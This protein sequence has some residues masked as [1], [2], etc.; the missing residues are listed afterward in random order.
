[1]S[2]VMFGTSANPPGLHHEVTVRFLASKF[3]RVDVWPCGPRT[4]GKNSTNGTAPIHRAAMADLAYGNI[5]GV[6]VESSDLEQDEF[7]RTWKIR[8][9]YLASGEDVW[10]AVGTDLV[11]GGRDG[12]SDIHRWER[13]NELWQ[14]AKFVV[15]AREGYEIDSCDLPPH[16][17]YFNSV[18]SG[19]S[20]EIRDLA[21]HWRPFEYLVNPN[22]ATYIKRHNLYRGLPTPAVMDYRIEDP[23]L[24]VVADSWN[25]EAKRMTEILAPLVNE[26]HPNLIVTLGGDGTM[27]RAIHKYWRLRVPFFGINLGHV[28]FLLNNIRDIF[29]PSMLAGNHVLLPSPLLHVE[30]WNETSGVLQKGLAFNDAWLERKRGGMAVMEVLVNGEVWIPRAVGDGMLVSTAAGSTAYA[31]AM[32]A[33]PLAVGDS[34]MLLVGSN[35]AEP[36]GWKSAHIPLDDVIEC[37]T[38]ER[39]TSVS[40]R[41]PL[42]GFVDG[43]DQGEVDGMRIRTSRI[44]AVELA[45]L[46][47]YD[48]RRKVMELQFPRS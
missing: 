5:P 20:S 15:I 18:Q 35:L 21:F 19:S 24:L 43:E 26:E 34:S 22:I 8:E 14:H 31:R 48:R 25:E 47:G 12:K 3:D 6:I 28:G 33:T 2:I 39:G 38:L 45:Y 41:R 44:A 9:K 46:H 36:F 17:Q 27:L 32:G 23:Q 11:K 1:M 10:L 42:Y 16:H 30:T 7:S 37:R 4:D 40:K 29:V 13:G